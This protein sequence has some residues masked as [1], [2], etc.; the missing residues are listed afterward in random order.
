M[1][2]ADKICIVCGTGFLGTAKAECCGATCRKKLQRLLADGKQPEFRLIGGKNTKARTTIPIESELRFHKSVG[3]KS[4]TIKAGKIKFKEITKES[5]DA[6][7]QTNI[8]D[9]PPR[10]VQ[11][12]N[13]YLA[14]RWKI[15]MG[16]K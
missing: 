8:Q 9:E 5:Y 6:P 16:I 11:P 13:R 2:K 4:K 10:Y 7:P 3:I 14:E 15:K 1:S 12:E